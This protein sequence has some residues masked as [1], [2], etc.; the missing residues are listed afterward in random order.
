VCHTIP[1]QHTILVQLKVRNMH[2]VVMLLQDSKFHNMLDMEFRVLLTD[3]VEHSPVE[4]NCF[5]A[6]QEIPHI[7]WNKFITAF[8][9]AHSEVYMCKN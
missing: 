3:C 8:I 4:A 9:S 1:V 5:S 2:N 7:L 6:S